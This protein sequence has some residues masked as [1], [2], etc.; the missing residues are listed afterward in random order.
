MPEAN[1]EMVIRFPRMDGLRRNN[2]IARHDDHERHV[3][4]LKI[5]CAHPAERTALVK[6][7]Q[8]KA[9]AWLSLRNSGSSQKRRNGWP[10]QV[11]TFLNIHNRAVALHIVPLVGETNHEGRQALIA[12]NDRIVG[13]Q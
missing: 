8:L 12:R 6:Q 2:V 9:S 13:E 7:V 1:G 10:S 11:T 5:L 4:G 3:C